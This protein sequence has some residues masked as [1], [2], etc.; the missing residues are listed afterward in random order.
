M[1]L[2]EFRF[3]SKIAA[4]QTSS[5]GDL[6]MDQTTNAP[7]SHDSVQAERKAY[8]TPTLTDFGSFA[9]ITQGTFAGLGPDNAIYS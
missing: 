4:L 7:V 5:T 6:K 2:C 1:A 3:G 9:E 8:S